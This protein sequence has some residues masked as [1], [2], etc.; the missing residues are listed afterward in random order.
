V[1]RPGL[2]PGTLGAKVRLGLGFGPESREA[3][4]ARRPF[5]EGADLHSPVV[6]T[7]I[8]GLR[9]CTRRAGRKGT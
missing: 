7:A 3:W 6:R 5:A 9:G 8:I 1:G 4:S 2:E